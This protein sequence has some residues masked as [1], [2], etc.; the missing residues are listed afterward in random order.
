LAVGEN[1]KPAID[2]GGLTWIN[3]LEFKI[4]SIR[5]IRVARGGLFFAVSL[6]LQRS[7]VLFVS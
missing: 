4:W 7:R 2:L 5:Q 3:A 6:F 1:S